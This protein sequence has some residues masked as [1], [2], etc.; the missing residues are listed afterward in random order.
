MGGCET[1]VHGETLHVPEQEINLNISFLSWKVLVPPE[2]WDSPDPIRE[3][4]TISLKK[5][6]L[7]PVAW[8]RSIH[9]DRKPHQVP[10]PRESALPE[11][12]DPLLNV[13]LHPLG[14]RCSENADA[15]GVQKQQQSRSVSKNIHHHHFRV[16]F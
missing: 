1:S 10:Q 5:N 8:D 3:W 6:L 12:G 15:A 16:G 7:N 9:P 13:S 14:G 4:R 2:F 11:P